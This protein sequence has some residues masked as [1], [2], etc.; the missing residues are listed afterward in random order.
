MD[1]LDAKE[2]DMVAKGIQPQ[3][4]ACWGGLNLDECLT[5]LLIGKF[6]RL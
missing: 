4:A 6:P 3:E 2:L 1:L 5:N